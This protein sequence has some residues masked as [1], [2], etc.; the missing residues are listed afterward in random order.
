MRDQAV[1][2]G[3]Q[4]RVVRGQARRHVVGVEQGHLGGATQAGAAHHGDV[5]P[6]DRQDAGAAVAGGADHADRRLL[7][8][9]RRQEGRQVRL[10]R[11]RA[12]ARAAAAVRDAEG[13]V[14][15]EVRHVRAVLAG[16]G[17]ADQ[18]IHV[19]AVG[20]DLAAVRVDDLADLDHRFL[21]HAVR[22]RVGDHQRGK[23]VRMLLRL[24]PQVGH[25]HVAVDVALHHHHLH[26]AHLRG[27]GVGAVRGL[28]DQADLAVRLAARAMVCP[29][30]EKPGEF[31]L[32]AGIRLQADGVVTRALDQH[33]LERVHQVAIALHLVGGRQRVDVREFR[34]G[35]RQHL[36]GGVE[37]HRA[38]AQRDH[39]AVH[40]QVLVGQLAQVAQQFVLAVVGVEDRV[41]HEV[42]GAVQR[43]RQAVGHGVVERVHV[44]RHAEQG[45]QC[46][47]VRAGAGLVEGDRELRAVDLAQ[48]HALRARGRVD[49]RGVHAGDVHGVEEAGVGGDAG[50]AQAGG[51][52]GGEPMRAAG[53]AA[54]AV[55]AM[56]DR[57]H[58]GHHRQQHLRGADVGGGLL[59][60]DVLFAGLQGEAVGGLAE[61]VDGHADQAARH[62][63]LEGVLAG[64]E[65]GM[66][67]AEAE[68]HAEALGVADHD[69]RAPFSRRHQQGERQQV[70][71][72]RDHAAARVRGFGDRPVV[73]H[74]AGAAGILQQHREGVGGERGG[75]VADLHVD[76]E[77]LGAGA[78]HGDRLRVAIGRD[79]EQVGLALA[80]ALGQG[81]RLGGGG[82]FVEQR[83]IAD[84]HPGQVGGH[85]LEVDQGL[86]AAL[87]DLG[88]VRR[89]GGVPGRVLQHVAQDHRRRVGAVVA[90]ADEAAE[91]LVAIGDPAD[92]CQRLGL[93][94]RIGQGQRVGQ[95]D[96]RRHDRVHHR[97][98]R[99]L[100]DDG[101]HVRHLVGIGTD[102]AFDEGVVMLE[103]AQ[104]FAGHG[105]FRTRVGPCE[106]ARRAPPCPFA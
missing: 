73:A 2:A 85:G 16:L 49:P 97:L 103:L 102:V 52:D 15:V 36:A 106:A 81:H 24:G 56:V 32:R 94:D 47:H 19:G 34:P 92:L 58:A 82:G 78:H 31:T 5:H 105:Q 20:V 95:L 8:V 60:A 11:G 79:E 83:G 10:H 67:A 104:A 37:L 88:L 89:V 50:R 74:L 33:G 57:V 35:H 1:A 101:E 18:R 28:G 98:Q 46:L 96:A 68:G 4:G 59:A 13:L 55:R 39:G 44:R 38:R 63:A 42:G 91:H 9:G 100:A 25:V 64:Q 29:D 45:P 99:R 22:G 51:E 43:R 27:S 84:L 53:D 41:G 86:H 77:A 12:H 80:G 26:A 30:G 40:R 66:R 23:A 72:R 71:G 7:A 69:V 76:A 3:V 61:R 65:C 90:L 14:Q 70:G 48:V 6:A 62:R 93:A 21:E 75:V 87:R 54:Q 17:D